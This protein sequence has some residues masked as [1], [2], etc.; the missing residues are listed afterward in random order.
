[1]AAQVPV[2]LRQ[3]CWVLKT[4]TKIRRG[5]RQGAVLAQA[6]AAPE[7]ARSGGGARMRG[8]VR[9]RC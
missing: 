4:W 8:Q 6:A 5:D 3:S 9:G 1:V 2:S 7:P